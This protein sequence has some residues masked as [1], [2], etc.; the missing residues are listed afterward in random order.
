MTDIDKLYDIFNEA[1]YVIV[2]GWWVFVLADE[3][4]W[5]YDSNLDAIDAIDFAV[6]PTTSDANIAA[7]VWIETNLKEL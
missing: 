4:L 1:D 2:R 6:T 5:V 3:R 7:E